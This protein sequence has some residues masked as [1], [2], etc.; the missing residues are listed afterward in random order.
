MQTSTKSNPQSQ[1]LP[2]IKADAFT[3]GDGKAVKDTKTNL[4]WLNFGINSG[5]SFNQVMSE[6]KTKYHG[7]RLPTEQEVRDL[8]GRLFA[9]NVSSDDPFQVFRLWGANKKPTD[10]LPYLSWGYF[11]D[12]QG[13]L[14]NAVFIEEGG[15]ERNPNRDPF[16]ANSHVKSSI[17]TNKEFKYDGS[18][19]PPFNLGGTQEMSTLLVLN[20]PAPTQFNKIHTT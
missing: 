9:K 2:L 12:S 6:L 7:W 1:P 5:D 3:P 8:W 18:D 15:P 20:S 17:V 19:Q 16:Y 13:F 11:L 4:I 10:H 14:A